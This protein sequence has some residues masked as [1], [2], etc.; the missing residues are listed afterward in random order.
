MHEMYSKFNILWSS[1]YCKA[2]CKETSMKTFHGSF[3]M[4]ETVAQM[5]DN[6]GWLK[7][8]KMEHH[9][10]ITQWKTSSQKFYVAL[11]I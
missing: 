9:K 5:W 6:T 8:K 1:L 2:K 4:G 3:F 11:H 7:N 10:L